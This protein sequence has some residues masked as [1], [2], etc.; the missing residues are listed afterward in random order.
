[1]VL[2]AAGEII[3]G[4][5]VDQIDEEDE[6][7]GQKEVPEFLL[8][9]DLKLCLKHLCRVAIRKHL[10]KV[11]PHLRLFDRIPQLGLPASLSQYLLYNVTI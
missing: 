11:N 7:C 5:T 4:T 6:I 9:K 1:M 2:L 10:I 8:I 3:E